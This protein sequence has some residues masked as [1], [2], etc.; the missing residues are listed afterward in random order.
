MRTI[1]LALLAA[2]LVASRG[3]TAQNQQP[4]F[5]ATTRLIVHP[6]TVTD[7]RGRPVPGLAAGDFDVTEDGTRQEIAFVEFQRLSPDATPPPLP[8]PSSE[9][10]AVARSEIL[11]PSPG[12]AR[13]RSRR[14][15]VFYFDLSTLSM[16][17]SARAFSSATA[18][19]ATRLTAADAVAIM[20][21]DGGAV[22]VRADFTD[23]RHRL[24]A[25]LASLAAGGDASGDGAADAVAAGTG[26][27]ENDAEFNLFSSDRQLAAL[28]RAVDILRGIPEQK[29]LIYLGG[30]LRLN[31][32]DNQAQIRATVNAATRANVTLNPIDARGLVAFAPMGDATR[33]SAGGTAL[34]SG[35]LAQG[36]L[37][38]LQRS[39]DTLHALAKD[40]GGTALFDHNDLVVGIVRAAEAVTSYYLIGYYSTHT[41]DDGRLRRVHVNVRGRPDARLAY[42][43]G[44]TADKVFAAFSA[45]DRER[46]L[47]E[48]LRLDQPITDVRM[49]VEINVFRLNRSEYFV[50]VSVR[51]PGRE[52]ALAR[53]RGAARTRLDV[54]GEVKDD[55]A[56]THRN[57]RD[58]LD[59]RLD[60]QA[61]EA[62]ADRSLHYETGFTLLP[63]DYVLKMLVR[64]AT[65]GR[66]GT[67]ETT[68]RIV[69]VESVRDVV[70][71]STIVLSSQQVGPDAALYSVQQKIRT[72]SVS[73]LIVDGRQWLP[74]VT[75]VFRAGIDLRVL[76]HAYR[77]A[78]VSPAPVLAYAGLYRDGIRVLESPPIVAETVS[79]AARD[80]I[81]LVMTLPLGGL[82]SGAYECQVTILSPGAGKAAFWRVP[83]DIVTK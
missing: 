69:N 39:Q 5:R 18:F 45:A 35:T 1:G 16:S 74:H 68:F 77:T 79:T 17:D 21:F 24:A 51:I 25:E 38:R 2:A 6:V 37:T 50:P 14:L 75:R 36:T 59:I 32:V 41:S 9:T 12:D 34:F 3:A 60:G 19:I 46:Q 57:L 58:E 48:A 27:G 76:V 30:G 20:T 28:Q 56:V 72:N 83:I 15:L 40:T 44:Y 22:R 8:S 11:I 62:W 47:E 53:S 55:H 54:I 63:G 66:I 49:A 52:I 4:A 71:T 80:A 65:T 31:G 13:Y 82:A 26:F 7:A 64:D 61:G 42:R 23:D 78:G 81:P 73:P 33:A 10:G 67:Y 29:T 43:A 70:P